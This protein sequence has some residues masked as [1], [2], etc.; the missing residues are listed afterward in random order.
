MIAPSIT[1]FTIGYISSEIFTTNLKIN[2][3]AYDHNEYEQTT[4]SIQGT[5]KINKRMREQIDQ[6]KDKL[7]NSI[8]PYIFSKELQTIIPKTVVL[9]KY[10][11]NNNKVYIEAKSYNQKS[12]DEF[13][14]FVNNH[15][16]IEPNTVN[17]EELISQTTQSNENQA[18]EYEV[19]L[20]QGPTT[21]Y[22]VKLNAQFR[23]LDEAA[24]KTKSTEFGDFYLLK[25]LSVFTAGES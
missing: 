8:H 2:K 20:A 12:I 5:E 1:L 19:Q 16:N 18:T 15:S 14:V 7:V 17:I 3:Y 25:K 23:M 9:K 22:Q 24:L 13:I 6:T 4:Q 10:E 11:I 21:T